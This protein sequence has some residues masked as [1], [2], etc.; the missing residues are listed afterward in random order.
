MKIKMELPKASNNPKKV[1]Q[2]YYRDI[3]DKI[4]KNKTGRVTKMCGCY[5]CSIPERNL[6]IKLI[7]NKGYVVDINYNSYGVPYL[8]I[9]W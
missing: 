2:K 5:S 8:I 7:Q 4:L 6:A 1:S 3:V 9:T